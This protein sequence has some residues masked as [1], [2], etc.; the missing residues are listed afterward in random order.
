[1]SS[2][3]DTEDKEK[4][5]EKEKETDQNNNGGEGY[6][7][8]ITG[9]T[10]GLGL[11]AAEDIVVRFPKAILVLASRTGFSLLFVLSFSLSSCSKLFSPL[12]S[13]LSLLPH[14]F[15]ASPNKFS[16]LFLYVQESLLC[17]RCDKIH[18]VRTSISCPLI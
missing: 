3:N 11:G 14:S 9:G 13:P 7:I 2:G 15:S 5:K 12:F 1:M 17:K 4:G 18:N 8:L 10:S 16:L 6:C